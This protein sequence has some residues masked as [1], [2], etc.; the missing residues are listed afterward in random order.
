MFIITN[1]FKKLVKLLNLNK[2][3]VIFDIETTG[4][5]IYKDKIVEIAYIKIW[6]DGRVKK[7]E[8]I[9]NPQIPI[10]REATAIHD[11]SKKDVQGKPTFRQK[12]QELWDVFNNCYYSGFNIMNFDLPILRREFIRVG[13]SFDYTISQIIDAKILFQHMSPRS[14]SSAYRHYCS[15]EFKQHHTALGDVEVT[16]EILIKQLEKYQEIRDWNF[17]NKIHQAPD[18]AYVDNTR[19]FYWR[20]GEAYFAFSKYRDVALSEVAKMH[21]E[22]LKWVLSADFSDET[23]NIV[24]KALEE[25]NI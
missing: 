18:N 3:L 17:V 25:T 24:K 9:F 2:P 14:L 23:K 16:A 12:A 15:K 20:N 10:T 6:Q 1:K 5:V 4:L 13:M 7:D 22:F 11:L 8:I 19:K 21:P